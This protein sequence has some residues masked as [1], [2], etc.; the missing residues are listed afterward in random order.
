MTS[1][2]PLEGVR[3]IVLT[4]AWA[5]AFCTQLLGLMGAEVVQIEARKRL[6]SWRGQYDGPMP[7]ALR[8]TATAQHAW[9]CN[10]LF[11]SVNLNKRELTLDLQ[12]PEGVD[13]F[14]RLV[15]Y[16]D[17]VAENF[18]PRVM[19]NLGIDYETL[20]EIRPDLI[21]C[22]LSAYGASGPWRNVPGIGGTI[23][24]T[25]GMSSLLGYEDGQPLNSGSMF[26]D[27]IA[28]YYGFAAIVTAL[29]HRHRTG[30]GQYIDLSMQEANLTFIGDAA[31][32]YA[33][34]GSVRGRTG[35]RH[36]TFAPHGIYPAR[37]EE[38]WIA[39]A[40]ET[41]EQWRALCDVAG[42][43]QWA[44]DARFADND[45]RK[46]NEDALDA[47]IASWTAEQSRDEMAAKL[48]AAGLPAAPVLDAHEVAA[49]PVFRE[50]GFVVD[51][52][53]PEAGRHPQIGVPFTLSRAAPRVTRPA[54]MLG[55]HSAE[56]LAELLDVEAE[57][58]EE[59]V[60]KGIT[61]TGPPEGADG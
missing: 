17:V 40:A 23:E 35:N 22:S 42:R 33:A 34:N 13:L 27:P 41:E 51:V 49:D 21:M 28:G 43:S 10:P 7:D 53:H 54:P 8:D 46:A 24:P 56:V 36:L 18:S 45:A 6:D 47:Q 32:E 1:P 29:H 38:Q 55:E 26:P 4:Q 3:A 5:G 44:D 57:E 16:A 52:E 9:N 61:G 12:T 11:N 20:R 48:T 15:P 2:M 25:S 59:L 14:K 39:L 58:Y 50:R 60:R 19:G 30:E 37:G 31:L